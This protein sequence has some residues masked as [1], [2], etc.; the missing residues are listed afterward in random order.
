[1]AI[2]LDKK[3]FSEIQNLDQRI[4]IKN[5][6]ISEILSRFYRKIIDARSFG[7]NKKIV[8]IVREFVKSNYSIDKL[9]KTLK[10]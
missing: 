9:E 5:R 4:E 2:N 7:K 3:K 8:K 1:M 6:K 10:S